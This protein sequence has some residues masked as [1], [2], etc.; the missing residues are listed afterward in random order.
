[1]LRDTTK[2]QREGSRREQ[3]KLKLNRTVGL[4]QCSERQLKD[5]D[6]DYY[7]SKLLKPRPPIVLIMEE[8][9][10]LGERIRES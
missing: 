8:T 6:P 3:A 9:T 4:P 2:F 1:V 7:I 10:S 5:I